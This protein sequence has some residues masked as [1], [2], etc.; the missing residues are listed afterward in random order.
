MDTSQAKARLHA[1]SQRL[2][3]GGTI[4]TLT[5]REFLSWFGVRRRGAWVVEDIR[6]ALSS[7]NLVTDPDFES[8]YIDGQ[9]QIKAATSTASVDV[10]LEG[11]EATASAVAV[12]TATGTLTIDAERIDPTHRISKLAAA[13]NA[14]VYV[15]PDSPLREA[16]TIMLA[17]GFSQLPVMTSPREVKGA[18]SWQSIGAHLG[19]GKAGQRARDVM[20]P[21]HEV[22]HESSIFQVIPLIVANDYVLVRGPSNAI[23]GIV[24]ASD[25]SLQFLQLSEPFLLLSEIENQIRELIAHRFDVTELAATKDPNDSSRSIEHVSDLTFGE[26]IRLLENTDNWAKSNLPLDRNVF[27]KQL[28]DVRDIRNDVMHFDPDGISPA[29]LEKLRE[30]ARFLQKLSSMGIA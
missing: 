17:R 9:I 23:T 7:E 27:C 5:V 10:A 30:F 25:L 1:L 20:E 28:G 8:T 13:N 21:H 24:T 26:Y 2:S 3:D 11:V 19:M 4:E 22:R 29:D 6:A 15:S 14:P 16:L 12:S 18:V